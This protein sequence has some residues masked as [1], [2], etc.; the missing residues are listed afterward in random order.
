MIS[1]NYNTQGSDSKYSLVV[2]LD[3]FVW[4]GSV[5]TG[6]HRHSFVGTKMSSAKP[7]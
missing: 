5:A 7:V 3:L 6:E 4:Y 1:G 2:L